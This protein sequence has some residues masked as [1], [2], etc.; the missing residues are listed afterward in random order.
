M[1]SDPPA[2][3]DTRFSDPEAAATPW[4]AVAQALADAELYW[5]TTVRADGRSH[6][7]PLV[8]VTMDGAVHFC[9]GPEEQ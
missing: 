9:T 2:A 8:G 1:Q 4:P 6:V 3:I 5:L 7:T